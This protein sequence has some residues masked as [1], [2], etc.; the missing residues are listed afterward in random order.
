V[1]NIKQVDGLRGFWRGA[2]PTLIRNVPGTS[3]YFIVLDQ[4]RYKFLLNMHKYEFL[5][6]LFDEKKMQPNNIGNGV[7]ASISRG[8]S[9]FIFMPITVLK[10]RFE[11]S[12][13]FII[14]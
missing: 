11:V 2:I 4:V 1:K 14:L 6:V 9:G 10:I 12:F 3:C 7:I 8:I 5:K 13:P